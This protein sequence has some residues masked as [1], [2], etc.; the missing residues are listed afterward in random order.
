MSFCTREIGECYNDFYR[1]DPGCADE[2]MRLWRTITDI[3]ARSE[4][5]D[6]NNGN[7]THKK[8]FIFNKPI[9][10]FFFDTAVYKTML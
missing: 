2:V 9:A 1:N 3:G 7:I 8:I 4:V 6:G 5:K 10:T